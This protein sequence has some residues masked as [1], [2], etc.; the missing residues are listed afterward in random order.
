MQ[1]AMQIEIAAPE[2]WPEVLSV[3]RSSY[4]EYAA[5]S[6]PAFWTVYQRSIE[7]TVLH[8]EAVVRLIAK[9]DDKVAASVLYCPPYDRMMGGS[10]VIN[11]YPEMR[12]LAVLPEF[13][14][15]KLAGRLIDKC[16]AMAV[17]GGFEKITLHT[18]VLMQTAKQ[19]Y[20]RRGYTRYPDI[21]FEPVAGF[22][23]WGYWK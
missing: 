17:S 20:E 13:R 14:G 5:Q 7:N 19:M 9:L 12:L 11:N 23:V 4:E 2:Y 16:E 22:V 1:E 10:R 6:D 8:D 21:D 3:T 18:T 15:A